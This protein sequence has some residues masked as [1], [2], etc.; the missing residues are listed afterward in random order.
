MKF[1][2]REE[3]LSSMDDSYPV[4]GS[5]LIVIYDRRRIG[6]TE[7]IKRFGEGKGARFVYYFCDNAPISEQA[8]RI[9]YSVG[10]AI[11]DNELMEIGASNLEA[12]FYRISKSKIP[13]KLIMALDEFQNLPKLDPAIPSMLQKAWDLYVKDSANLMLILCGSSISMMRNDVLNYSAPLYGRSTSI[14][15]LKPLSFE[16]AMEL[17]PKNAGIIDRLYAY[18]IFGG[19]PAY[20]AAIAASV[21]DYDRAGIGEIV[22]HMLREGSVFG[23]EPGLLLS[24]EV[25]NDTR[26][27]QILELIAN[28]MN[29]PSEIASKIGIAHANLNKY[30]ELLEYVDL[31]RKELP[32]TMD[33]LRKSKR[34]IYSIIDNFIDFYFKV[35]KKEIEGRRDPASIVKSLDFIA[36]ARFEGMA[37]DFLVFLSKNGML[38][39]IDKIGRWWGADASRKSGENQEGIDAVA[40]NASTKDILFAECKW[41]SKPIGTDVYI[42]LKRKAKLVN[43]HNDNRKEHFAL[44]SKSGFDHNMK[45]L[46][47]KEGVLLFDPET[48]E[49]ALALRHGP[50]LKSA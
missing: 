33:A 38:F 50:Q 14:F 42:G 43:W 30:M 25:R 23:S 5:N 34:G 44:F 48:I 6:K 13:Y 29:K 20:Y 4:N 8:R 7:L 40:F 46:S 9:S 21:K 12:V 24:E 22:K 19:I 32:V 17:T 2:D 47:K 27:M 15:R 35:L 49:Q 45:E 37:K 36:Q 11:G 26:Y 3:E 28:G 41:S 39:P 16:H 10:K 1:V 31:V 18:F